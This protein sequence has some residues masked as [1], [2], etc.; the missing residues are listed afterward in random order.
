LLLFENNGEA[1]G[2]YNLSVHPPLRAPS[3]HK[4]LAGPEIGGG[5][6]IADTWSEDKEVELPACSTTRRWDR[7]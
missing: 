6:F 2:V 1:V 4:Y 7:G 5:N 3:L